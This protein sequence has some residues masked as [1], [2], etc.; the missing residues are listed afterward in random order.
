MTLSQ[1]KTMRLRGVKCIV[2]Q[3]VSGRSEWNPGFL[4]LN[5]I[6]PAFI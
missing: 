3:L 5:M 6:V 4:S 2:T 1:M